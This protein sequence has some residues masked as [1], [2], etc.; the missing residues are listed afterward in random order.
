MDEVNFARV[1]VNGTTPVVEGFSESLKPL[2]QLE[3]LRMSIRR[4]AN[5]LLNILC[6]VRKVVK[7][8]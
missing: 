3:H 6:D 2:A 1:L 4:S 8:R 7:M 5:P